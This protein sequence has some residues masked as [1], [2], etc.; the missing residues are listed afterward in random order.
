MRIS[1]VAVLLLCTVACG[2]GS[3]GGEK[4]AQAPAATDETI[5]QRVVDYFKKAVSQ[6]GLEF[7]VTKLEDADIPGWRKGNLQATLGE[8]KQDVAFFITR[9]GRYLFR[10]EAIDLT[11]DPFVAL[12]NEIDLKDQPVRGPADA[13]VT[14]VEY[15][16]FECPFCGKAY[17]TFEKEVIGQYGD[18]V[19]FVFKN[20]PLTQIHPWAED[21]AVATECA[22]LQGNDQHWIV[23]NGLFSQQGSINKDN[24]PAKVEE[25]ANAS[26]GKIDVAKLKECLAS[27]QTLEAVKK[28]MAEAQEVG[29]TSTP[30]FIINGRRL[31]GAQ[32]AAAFKQAIDQALAAEQPKS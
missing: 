19:K 16:D 23:Y 21:A 10:G 1:A 28:D 31:N 18:K 17:D 11:V 5:N 24:L 7:K 30:A 8:Q 9:D 2:G 14:I 25:I 26:G 29:V 4:A 12:M 32:E 3:G 20:L 15:S 27:K 6:P 22:F 13:K